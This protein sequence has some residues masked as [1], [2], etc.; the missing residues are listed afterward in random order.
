MTRKTSGEVPT[1]RLVILLKAAKG[2]HVVDVRMILY[3]EAD[4]RYS[5]IHF[6]DGTEKA[7]FHT[8]SELEPILRCGERI[9]DL[10]FVR[11]QKSYLAA[12]HHATAIDRSSGILFNDRHRVPIGRE[13]WG[14]VLGVVMAVHGK[15]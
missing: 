4:S 2:Y 6:A 10:L 8:L 14:G 11:S 13:Y 15:E 9:G 5:R 7:V 1:P 12:I 3:A